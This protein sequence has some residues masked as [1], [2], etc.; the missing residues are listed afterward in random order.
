[1]DVGAVDLT[2]FFVMAEPMLVSMTTSSFFG[3]Q[4]LRYGSMRLQNV[5]SF[6]G[7]KSSDVLVSVVRVELV[8][9]L[10]FYAFFYSKGLRA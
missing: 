3:R 7:L 6:I 8:S 4:A 10:V 5:G 9:V 2:S 1:M